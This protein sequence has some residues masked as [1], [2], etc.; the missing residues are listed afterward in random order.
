MDATVRRLL[1]SSVALLGFGCRK[2]SPVAKPPA[3]AG[4]VVT[5]YVPPDAVDRLMGRLTA[6]AASHQWALSV[7]TDAAAL[8]EA[9]LVVA[10]SAGALVGRLR[11]G[12]PAAAQARQLVD[13]ALR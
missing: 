4:T 11:P 3:D 1:V 6:V 13:A 5:V 8:A 9:D 12:S 7:R 10:D 2:P